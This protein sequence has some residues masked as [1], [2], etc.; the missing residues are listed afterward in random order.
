MQTRDLFPIRMIWST[1]DVWVNSEYMMR[2]TEQISSTYILLEKYYF[3]RSF[4]R[5]NTDPLKVLHN[6]ESTFLWCFFHK[7][8]YELEP[9]MFFTLSGPYK[10]IH[11]WQQFF[12]LLT[13]FNN[14]QRFGI[15]L[16]H[17]RIR[18]LSQLVLS[19]SNFSCRFLNPII[20]FNLN[21]NCFN[22]EVCTSMWYL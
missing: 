6:D 1:S 18:I 15:F 13:I 3:W 11:E 9:C 12:L 2:F 21:L 19:F 22:I 5:A 14:L 7:Q 4:V 16:D 8:F 17:V 10:V 20:F